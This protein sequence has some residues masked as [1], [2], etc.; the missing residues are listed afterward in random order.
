MA[1]IPSPK[2][3]RSVGVCSVP[4]LLPPCGASAPAH[5]VGRA[6]PAESSALGLAVTC[7]A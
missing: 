2:A 6:A 7:T 4:P 3:S 5:S 1:S